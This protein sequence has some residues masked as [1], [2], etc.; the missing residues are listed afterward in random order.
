MFTPSERESF[1]TH[2]LFR[3]QDFLSNKK[4]AD[5]R[6]LIFAHLEH[7]GIWRDGSWHFEQTAPDYGMA[8]IKPLNHH[9]TIVELASGEAFAAASEL[10]DDPL[11]LPGHPALL[12]TLPNATTWTLP[13]QNWHVDTPL[14]PEGGVP[15]VQIFA[16]LERVEAGGGGTLAVMGSHRLVREEVRMSSADLRK[17]LERETYFSELMSNS[18]DDR[19]RFLNEIGH[20]GDVELKVAEMTGEPGDVYF[21]NMRVLH[22]ISPNKL[23]VPRIT[24]TQRYRRQ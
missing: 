21:M 11:D 8:L 12:F 22:T 1:T 2:G 24:L 15:G 3:R 17:K 19:M 7:A 6:S 23:R 18:T 5:A 9:P 16:I 20:V 13:Y 10:A 4:L 14:L